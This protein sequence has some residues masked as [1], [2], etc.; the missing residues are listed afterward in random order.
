MAPCHA[1]PASSWQLPWVLW[2]QGYYQLNPPPQLVICFPNHLKHRKTQ[3]SAS[4]LFPKKKL[5]R[6]IFQDI[7]QNI[8]NLKSKLGRFLPSPI[9]PTHQP[10]R[11]LPSPINPTH[12][13]SRF[14][15]SP[16]NPTDQPSRFLPSPINPTH[17]PSRFLPSPINPTHQPSRF[18]P[19]PINPTHQPSRFLPSPINPTHQPSRFLPSPI[20]PTHQPSRFLPSPINPTHGSSHQNSGHLQLARHRSWSCCHAWM[21]RGWR[22]TMDDMRL[23]GCVFFSWNPFFVVFF[24]CVCHW[25]DKHSSEFIAN[26]I[27]WCSLQIGSMTWSILV[28]EW[29]LFSPNPNPKP[30]KATNTGIWLLQES[31]CSLAATWSITM[32]CGLPVMWPASIGM[33]DL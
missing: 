32:V 23:I 18:L 1:E 31:P 21:G 6:I 19:S 33:G 12:Q 9:N 27:N 8:K 26:H 7:Q 20:N 2:W 24:W 10:S 22:M 30:A 3:T 4:S 29:V 14:L 16:I 28:L 25:W 13:P 15:P 17:Q 5:A 11:F